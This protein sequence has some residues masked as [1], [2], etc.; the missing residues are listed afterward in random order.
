[1]KECYSWWDGE[2]E[3]GDFGFFKVRLYICYL[4]FLLIGYFV[5]CGGKKFVN[6]VVGFV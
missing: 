3:R 1:M 4:F 5:V 2:S 6:E